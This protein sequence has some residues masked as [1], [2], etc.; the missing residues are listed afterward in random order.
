MQIHNLVVFSSKM[1]RRMT[2]ITYSMRTCQLRKSKLTI[3]SSFSSILSSKTK[4]RLG[5]PLHRDNQLISP[6]VREGKL[7]HLAFL[8]VDL[9]KCPMPAYSARVPTI[10]LLHPGLFR[11][12][13]SLQ[14]VTMTMPKT[15]ACSSRML[16]SRSMTHK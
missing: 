1:M 2:A 6:W 8:P 4:R 3:S 12:H 5:R 16:A 14:V 9:I 13:I 11:I 15:A 10:T 7:L